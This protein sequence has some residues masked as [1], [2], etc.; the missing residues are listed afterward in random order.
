VAG[1][2][3][4]WVA[5]REAAEDS[6]TARDATRLAATLGSAEAAA[7]G[8]DLPP[9]WHWLAF[10]PAVPAAGLGADGHPALGQFLPPLEGR[11]RMWAG[12][13]LRFGAPLKVGEPLYRASEI[14]AIS[15]KAGATGSLVFVTVKHLV[16][17]AG[18]GQV[19]EEQ[20]I[21]YAALPDRFTPPPKQAAAADPAFRHPV[22]VDPVVLF[23][24]SALTFNA[25]RIHYDRPYAVEAEKYP[26]LVV[27]GPLQA[28]WMMEAARR[29]AGRA[30]EQFRFRGLHPLFPEDAPQVLGWT[31]E[32]GALTLAVAAAAGHVTMQG[33]ARFA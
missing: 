11:R 31:G 10:A 1:R 22:H 20:D 9:L 29:Q 23:R 17:G 5:R 30:P 24:F 32:A 15:E 4:D 26:S 14:M 33:E 8:A 6:V 13:R 28:V 7:D 19:E 21:V 27:H 12:G 25:H 16:T 2:Y 3:D 18:G